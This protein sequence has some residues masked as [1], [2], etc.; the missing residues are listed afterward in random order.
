MSR[1]YAIAKVRGLA[2][3]SGLASIQALTVQTC[4]GICAP[5]M[6]LLRKNRIKTG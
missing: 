3:L 2:P 1:E 6:E 5:Q 4:M